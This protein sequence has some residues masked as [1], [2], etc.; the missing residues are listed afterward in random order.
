M[1]EPKKKK[2]GFDPLLTRYSPDELE[3][4]IEDY[5]E[6]RVRTR[7]ITYHEHGQKK[8][9]EEDYSLP[10]TYAGLARHIGLT[11]STLWRFMQRDDEQAK[12]LQP[13]LAGALNRI[14]EFCEEA[15]FTR[16]GN[17][18]ARFALEVN[19]RYGKEDQ[20]G[21]GDPFVQNIIP[22]AQSE[23]RTAIPVWGQ[24]EDDDE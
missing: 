11:R 10:P 5:F 17:Q 3:D 19:H 21:S 16:E 9:L 14:A 8:E 20:A 6:S 24:D 23:L 15:L 18:G 22:P 12:I 2:R 1:T 4:L 13:A 7:K